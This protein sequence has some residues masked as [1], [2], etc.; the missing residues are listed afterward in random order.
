MNLCFSF[1]LNRQCKLS[2]STSRKHLRKYSASA[3]WE[4]SYVWV[5]GIRKGAW[6]FLTFTSDWSVLFLTFTSDW[7]VAMTVSFNRIFSQLLIR[8]NA[9]V[10]VKDHLQCTWLKL[11]SV[12][13]IGPWIR[14]LQFPFGPKIC[15]LGPKRIV[16]QI[17]EMNLP[18]FIQ[19]YIFW[20]EKCPPKK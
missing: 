16:S 17:T 5:P 11:H 19:G 8:A 14:W 6:L 10:S 20:C 15:R 1:C 13:Y 12:H 18:F 3:A 7:I 2:A 9:Y 4:S